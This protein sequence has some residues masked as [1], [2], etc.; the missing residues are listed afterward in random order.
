MQSVD[1]Q[2]EDLRDRI[3]RA[4]R[5]AGREPGSV[6]L[7]AVSKTRTADDI[8]RVARAGVR[9]VGENYVTEALPKIAALADCGLTWHFIGAI[10]SN[11]TRD[12]ALHFDWVHT[13]DR[14]KIARRLSDQ[15]PATLDPL[16]VLIQV[17]VD[18]EPQKA[19]VL[20]ERLAELA[21]YVATLPRLRLRGLMGIPRESAVAEEQRTAF[22]R[23]AQLFASCRPAREG[24]WDSLSMGMSADF[25][26]AISEGATLIRLGT[27]IFGPRTNG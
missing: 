13:V 21:R 16:N 5:D 23:L 9:D 11:K 20:E 22:R 17:N 19:G 6:R 8:R 3:L 27:A 15:R 24:D 25:E 14:E 10:Q 18:R 2:L 26:I 12:I 1:T 7:V 4:A